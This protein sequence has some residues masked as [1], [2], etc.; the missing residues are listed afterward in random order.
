MGLKPS[1]QST[2]LSGSQVSVSSFGKALCRIGRAW[3]INEN[4]ALNRAWESFHRNRKLST[5]FH[6]HHSCALNRDTIGCT[7]WGKLGV[8]MPETYFI[9]FQKVQFKEKGWFVTNYRLVKISTHL[10]TTRA[11]LQVCLK[12]LLH[13]SQVDHTPIFTEPMYRPEWLPNRNY[14][15]I[16]S[17]LN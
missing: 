9:S 4:L 14:I 7:L 17:K 6:S 16:F 3:S 5:K 8:C 2:Q 15:P 11:K 1:V 12:P 13:L 10:G